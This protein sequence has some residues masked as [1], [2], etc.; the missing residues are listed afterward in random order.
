[1]PKELGSNQSGGPNTVWRK[2]KQINGVYKKK[3]RE[4]T[5]FEGNI[6]FLPKSLDSKKERQM[7]HPVTWQ[8][9]HNLHFMH[10][11]EDTIFQSTRRRSRTTSI[12][13]RRGWPLLKKKPWNSNHGLF[14]QDSNIYIKFMYTIL[15][16]YV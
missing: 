5:A 13:Q 8:L 14:L 7:I 1:M 3:P 4:Q 6:M 12:H 11:Q 2:Q 10:R 9:G 16:F 15:I